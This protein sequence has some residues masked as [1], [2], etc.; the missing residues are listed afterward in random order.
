MTIWC[1]GWN[2]S[3]EQ[4]DNASWGAVEK[5]DK[6]SVGLVQKLLLLL[7]QKQ[8]LGCVLVVGSFQ[9]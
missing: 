1:T 8:Q 9:V 3:L 7:L 5:R 4:T 2:A 6:P